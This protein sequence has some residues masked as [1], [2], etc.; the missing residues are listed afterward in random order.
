M[1]AALRDPCPDP[2]PKERGTVSAAIDAR[3]GVCSFK[4]HYLLV[5]KNVLAESDNFA[6]LCPRYRSQRNRFPLV[7]LD[8]SSGHKPCGKIP[9][10]GNNYRRVPSRKGGLVKLAKESLP[11]TLPTYGKFPTRYAG[12]FNGLSTSPG[13]S[14]AL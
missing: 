1:L 5:V 9:V 11:S 6:V 10:K 14:S 2:Y 8:G 7:R 4:S 3:R 13:K 12:S